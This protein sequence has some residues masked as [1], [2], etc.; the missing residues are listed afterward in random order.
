ME[1]LWVS[2]IVLSWSR[3]PQ[4]FAGVLAPNIMLDRTAGSHALAATG[5]NV[6][7]RQRKSAMSDAAVVQRIAELIHAYSTGER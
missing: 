3:L 7:I 1:W 2:S 6:R 4:P 5:I